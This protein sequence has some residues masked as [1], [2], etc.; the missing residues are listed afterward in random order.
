[1]TAIAARAV[2]LCLLSLPGV[3]VVQAFVVQ[4]SSSRTGASTVTTSSSW[5]CST[6][7]RPIQQ[8]STRAASET[9]LQS[10]LPFPEGGDENENEDD[11]EGGGEEE[12][13]SAVKEGAPPSVEVFRDDAT[14]AAAVTSQI[15]VETG[16]DQMADLQVQTLDE[17]TV[18]VGDLMAS[19][20]AKT[21]SDVVVVSCLSHFGD[22]NAWELTQ[23]YM[24]AVKGG[25]LD[26]DW[27]VVRMG[28]SYGGGGGGGG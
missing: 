16:M 6:P 12:A 8:S 23:Q 25:R 27:Y 21:K 15:S 22:F 10:S 7:S 14:A 5:S 28:T 17:A 18:T 9:A 11:A 3:A 1:M 2:L 24:A 20:G 26:G 19:V 4:P 13:R